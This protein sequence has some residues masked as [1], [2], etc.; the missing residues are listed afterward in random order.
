[1]KIYMYDVCDYKYHPISLKKFRNH[2]ASSYTVIL[3]NKNAKEVFSAKNILKF[4][5]ILFEQDYVASS[6]QPSQPQNFVQEKNA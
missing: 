2:F 5:R 4:I 1:M 6:F 3:E